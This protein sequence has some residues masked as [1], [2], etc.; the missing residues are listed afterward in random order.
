M[1]CCGTLH[2]KPGSACLDNFKLGIVYLLNSAR[3]IRFSV[4]A[5]HISLLFRLNSLSI[6]KSALFCYLYPFSTND[7]QDFSVR[8][9]YLHQNKLL[10]EVLPRIPSRDMCH[11]MGSHFRPCRLVMGFQVW[12][13][14]LVYLQPSFE[15]AATYPL[16]PT[17]HL[18]TDSL[19]LFQ[20]G[21]AP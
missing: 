17:P 12:P 1:L 15:L 16:I 14:D 3:A 2:F 5:A 10:G 4:M 20:H 9:R 7:N 11:W 19:T 8:F 21:L 13:L 18:L 6:Q